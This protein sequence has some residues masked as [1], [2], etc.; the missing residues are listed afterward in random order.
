MYFC[1]AKL[2]ICCLVII[3]VSLITEAASKEKIQGLADVVYST[4]PA[5]EYPQG[6]ITYARTKSDSDVLIWLNADGG[7][8]SQSVGKIFAALACSAATP[9]L[10]PLENHHVLV[11]KAVASV[12]NVQSAAVGVL[13]SKSS[14]KYRIFMI[15][16]NRLKED[17]LPLFEQNL[18]AAADQVYTYPMKE[19]A[20]NALG[21][22]LQ[23]H[24]PAEDIIQ[25][26]LEFHNSNELCIVPD[27]NDDSPR[28][29]RI[30]C[31]MGLSAG[32]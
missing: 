8:A 18:K 23:K 1:G 16:Q 27:D 5:G 26:V 21:K 11:A 32:S 19:T 13:G 31:S 6:V 14:T 10:P 15:L 3:V 22:M 30:I 7:V 28:T 29:A 4:K 12:K 9:K 25:T 17:V 20:R 2:I 24:L